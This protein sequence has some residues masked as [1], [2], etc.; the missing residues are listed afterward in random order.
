MLCEYANDTLRFFVNIKCDAN[1][2]LKIC[3]VRKKGS[4]WWN[5]SEFKDGAGERCWLESG[6][7]KSSCFHKIHFV[8]IY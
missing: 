7:M 6:S 2:P 8:F 1:M 5:A 4:D 3:S